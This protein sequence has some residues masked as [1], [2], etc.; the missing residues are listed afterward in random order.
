MNLAEY[1]ELDGLGLAE[2]VARGDVEPKELAE[3]ALQGVE[4]VNPHLNA[5]I[6]TFPERAAS[7][8]R[9]GLPDGLFRGV[10]FLIKDLGMTEE[11]VRSEYC[12]RLA[13]G[14]VADHDTELMVRFRNAGFVNLGRTTTPEM[15]YSTTTETVLHG[16]TRN[17]WNTGRITD[18][19]SGGACAA[20]AAGVVPVAHASDGGGSI[21]G[22][23]ACCGVVGLKPTRGRTP[24]GPDNGES[25]SGL[26]I[27]FAVTRTVR[28]SAAL[29]D[30]IAGPGVGDP[31]VIPGPDHPYLDVVDTRPGKQRVAFSTTPW[32]GPDSETEIVA[33]VEATAALCEEMGHEV[34]EASPSFDGDAFLKATHDVWCAHLAHGIDHL[35]DVV[36]RVPG[37]DN[38]E[39]CTWACYEYGRSL[40]ACDLLR[41]LDVFNAVSRRVAPFFCEFDLFVTPNS[42]MLAPP[43]G[44]F[45]QNAP[46]LDAWDWTANLFSFDTFLPLYNTT[47]QPAISLPLHQSKDGLPIGI[48]F[49]ARFGGEATLLRFAAA[50]EEALPWI[51]R[52]PTIHVAHHSDPDA[53][54]AF[55]RT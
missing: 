29:L 38:L 5:V 32:F 17:P 20:V 25:L 21:R 33:A 2:L 23:A 43:I 55:R 31:Y 53:V 22:P 34:V 24:T 48:H 26:G 40:K 42:S 19:S 7:L 54:C 35:A 51:D 14:L 3:L 11:G 13:E 36:G 12:S 37:P 52:Q 41:G 9:E 47:G 1:A 45:D 30:E 44:T 16:A 49:A 10:P 15:G 39:R 6:E 28:D 18:G 50:L 8:T 46:V 4:A 27:E